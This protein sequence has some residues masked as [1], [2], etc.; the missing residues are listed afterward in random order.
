MMFFHSI[1]YL[2]DIAGEAFHVVNPTTEIPANK[3]LRQHGK[4]LT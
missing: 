2:R 4:A 1:F 3:A